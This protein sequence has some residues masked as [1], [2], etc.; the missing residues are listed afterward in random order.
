[1]A[2]KSLLTDEEF[3]ALKSAKPAA[4]HA[5]TEELASAGESLNRVSEMLK[6][7]LEYNRV[8]AI[9]GY[10]RNRCKSCDVPHLI[11]RRCACPHHQAAALLK[12]LGVEVEIE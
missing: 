7:I 8:H 4:H 9:K 10:K 6:K 12:S 11:F 5:F 1:M 2:G 3:N